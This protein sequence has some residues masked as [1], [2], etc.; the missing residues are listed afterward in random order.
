[1][2]NKIT[3][4]KIKKYRLIT[5]EALGTAINSVAKGKEKHAKEIIQMVSDYLSD[6]EY[7]EKKGDLVN[8]FAAI[9]YAHGWLDAGARLDVF[10]V[11]DD[12][13]FT[14]K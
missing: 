11:K 6:S 1:M 2:Q 12:N 4:E 10:N 7:F 3:S 8:S 14:I 13:L 9:N 5:T